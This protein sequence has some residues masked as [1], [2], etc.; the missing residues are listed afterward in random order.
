MYVFMYVCMYVCIYVCIYY[1]L[2]E[3]SKF[4][5]KNVLRDFCPADLSFII[6]FFLRIKNKSRTW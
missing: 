6:I 5:K 2:T 1:I 4:E 3:K